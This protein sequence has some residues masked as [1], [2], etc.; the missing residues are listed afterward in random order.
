MIAVLRMEVMSSVGKLRAR[1]A[2]IAANVK[3]MSTRD[4]ML[5]DPVF[6]F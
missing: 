2:D 6:A 3:T 1:K 5:L 4:G